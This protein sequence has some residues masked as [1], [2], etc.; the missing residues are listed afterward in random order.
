MNLTKQ[1]TLNINE[2]ERITNIYRQRAKFYDLVEKLFN[3]I[4]G[5]W[6]Y[7]KRAVKALNLQAGDT[8]VDLCCGTGLNFSLL[9]ETVGSKG[10]II[11]VD[12][13]D[14]M[15]SQAQKRVEDNDWSNVE[16]VLGDAAS[17]QFPTRIDGIISTWAITLVPEFERAIENGC[18]ALSAG[19]RWVI[20]DWKVP[21]NWLSLFAP[22]ISFLFLRPFGGN[23]KMATRHPWES[24]NKYLKN[25]SFTELLLGFA[26]IAVG[27]RKEEEE[28]YQE[29]SYSAAVCN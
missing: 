2:R 17:Y 9:Q 25:T 18:Q 22:P 29:H 27:E 7:R 10:K 23:L 5:A 15:L 13:T 21:S 16:L 24:I 26:Y 8:V 20:L 1:N 19:A 6:S 11:G 12:L 14:G 28:Y 4:F 3:I